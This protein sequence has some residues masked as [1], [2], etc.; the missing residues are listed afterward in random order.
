MVEFT[1]RECLDIINLRVN[2]EEVYRDDSDRNISYTYWSIGNR[3]E[4][5]WIF[6]RFDSFLESQYEGLKVIKQL[7]A[8]HLFRYQSGN[9]F[10]RHRD[11][12][13][14]NQIYNVGVN[15]TDDYE[16]GDF[17]LY[18][19]DITIEKIRGKMYQ[20]IHSREHEV[21]EITKGER[22]SLIGFYFYDNIN[23]KPPII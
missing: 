10:V 11:I 2:L 18:N 22:W 14:P 4:Y 6:D 15:L 17:K 1:H 8:I 23:K 20:F 13:Y 12:Y 3:P 19:P 7:D 5:K 16:G 9:M 21:T